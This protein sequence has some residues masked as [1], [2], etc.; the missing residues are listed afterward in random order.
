MEESTGEIVL[1][2]GKNGR[3]VTV[4]FAAVA[5]FAVIVGGIVYWRRKKKL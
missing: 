1:M 3:S 5:A 2:K 4:I